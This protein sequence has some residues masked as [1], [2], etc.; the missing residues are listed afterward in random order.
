MESSTGLKSQDRAF[1][2]P[3]LHPSLRT[4][5]SSTSANSYAVRSPKL[6]RRQPVVDLHPLPVIDSSELTSE[7]SESLVLPKAEQVLSE[8]QLRQLYDDEEID[9]FLHIF[10]AYVREVTA[11][12]IPATHVGKNGQVVTEDHS[13]V[14]M[15]VDHEGKLGDAE[16]EFDESVDEW[17]PLDQDAPSPPPSLPRYPPSDIS[18]S[19][20][21]ALNYIVPLL[22]AS[23]VRVDV[24]ILYSL[25]R[26]KALPYP[27]LAELR[28]HWHEVELAKEFSVAVTVRL[29]AAPT[30]DVQDVWNLFQLYVHTR[31]SKKAAK[32]DVK[33]SDSQPDDVGSVAEGVEVTPEEH[34]GPDDTQVDPDEPDAKAIALNAINEISDL[35]ERVKNTFLWRRPSSS[36]KYGIAL[37]FVFLLTLLPAKYLAKLSGFVCGVAFWHV[38]PILVAI[39]SSDRA[40]IPVPFSDVPTD[41]DYA[42][43]LISQRVA[44][45]LD[46]KPKRRESDRNSPDRASISTAGETEDGERSVNSSGVHTSVNWRKWGDRVVT[47]KERTSDLKR[48]FQG[49]QWKRPENW[50]ALN[51]LSPQVALQNGSTESRLQAYTFPAQYAKATGLITLTPTTLIFTSLLS[52]T[53]R[54]SISTADI[55]GVKKSGAMRGLNVRWMEVHDDGQGEERE[56]KFL[57]V[58]GRNELFARLIGLG[59]RRW[60]KV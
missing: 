19:E 25:F 46:V 40:R 59:G 4:R 18:L 30:H 50:M 56:A 3:P 23:H 26:R 33:A 17:A 2:P 47:T 49:G 12:D 48:L 1:L 41:A 39:P 32:S 11:S 9:R 53:A 35:H 5:S 42:M 16:C 54:L 34:T 60:A 38:V 20:R 55:L 14:N 37:F 15:D 44:R 22:P 57:W 28:R 13:E 27:T 45:G 52:N 7:S 31:K 21:I 36:V 6:P 58:G 8:T 43:D 51:P 10:A 29:A 24:Q